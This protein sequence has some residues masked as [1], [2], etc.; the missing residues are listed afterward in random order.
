[1]FFFFF[2]IFNFAIS[3][4]SAYIRCIPQQYTYYKE[5]FFKLLGVFLWQCT[6]FNLL[7]TFSSKNIVEAHFCEFISKSSWGRKPNKNR[8]PKAHQEDQK[9]RKVQRR[10]IDLPQIYDKLQICSRIQICHTVL[11]Q[12]GFNG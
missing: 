3:D 9:A 11:R 6:L 10:N 7:F 12:N 2:Y 4:L 1:M 5:V 8:S